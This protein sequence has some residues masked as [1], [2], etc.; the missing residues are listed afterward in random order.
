MSTEEKKKPVAKKKKFAKTETPKEDKHLS[1][2]ETDE[3]P[4][5]EIVKTDNPA[6][7]PDIDSP[8]T[9]EE[10][11]ATEAEDEGLIPIAHPVIIAPE[12]LP[13]EPVSHIESEIQTE[14]TQDD[15]FTSGDH[16]VDRLEI[17]GD[18]ND[19]FFTDADFREAKTRKVDTVSRDLIISGRKNKTR[20]PKEEKGNQSDSI[21]RS[22][23]VKFPDTFDITPLEKELNDVKKT[24]KVIQDKLK[25]SKADAHDIQV[26]TEEQ[27][28]CLSEIQRLTT[29]MQELETLKPL[30][31]QNI[32]IRE[33]LKKTEEEAR[34]QAAA[35]RQKKAEKL[36]AGKPKI[37]LFS[38]L[39]V[40]GFCEGGTKAQIQETCLKKY[41]ELTK[42]EVT[43]I[44]VSRKETIEAYCHVAFDFVLETLG[45]GYIFDAQIAQFPDLDAEEEDKLNA[46]KIVSF[47]MNEETGENEDVE[48][49][50]SETIRFEGEPIFAR[51]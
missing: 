39:L 12:T 31:E 6:I 45:Q 23:Q 51:D 29:E 1:F 47:E 13:V 18:Q 33:N 4:I 8:I 21:M 19:F 28:V 37:P 32:K 5:E 7:L 22:F 42:Q 46:L 44:S 36:K 20:Y 41:A 10:L 30:L 17:D 16:Y 38:S 24:L 27:R 15:F 2:K 35:E 48:V 26:L 50:Y 34:K 40:F 9:E 11:K 3:K 43:Q 49:D 14:E 25:D